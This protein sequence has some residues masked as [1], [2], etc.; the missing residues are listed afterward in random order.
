[1]AAVDPQPQ[2]I[3]WTIE[4]EIERASTLPS[5]VYCEPR[6]FALARARVFARGWQWAG[7]VDAARVPGQVQPFTL[8]E[9]LLDE[10]LLLARDGQDALRCLS[11]VCTHRGTVLCAGG[12]VESV[13]RCR[14]H[15]RR[16]ALDGRMLSMPE[17]EGVAGFP[18]S[19]DHLR[20]LPLGRWGKFLF[21]SLAG[22]GVAPLPPLHPLPPI[23]LIPPIV[24]FDDWI[25]PLV[26]RLRWLPLDAAVFDPA[27][28]RDYL[29]RAHWALYCDNYLE[30][31]HIPYVHAGLAGALDYGAYRTELYPWASLQ[32]GVASGGEDV[33]DLPPESPDHGQAIAAYYYWLFPNTMVNVYPWG[34]SVNVVR[35]LAVD[36]TKVSFL[37]YV[38]DASRL[39]SGA[40]AGLDR[41]ERED[42]AV[43]ESVQRGL[44][45]RIYRRGRYSPAREQG[46][47]HFHR[48]LT[49]CLAGEI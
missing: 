7:D 39:D 37:S 26:E 28:S 29:V 3:D 32:L 11:N 18:G 31:F 45:S 35:P 46:V 16:F 36:R 17:F 23:P 5:A 13:L 9:G 10:P 22:A 15:G 21:V 30:G 24:P 47:H 19:A 25:A 33:F 38:W 4:P 12:G 20:Q 49:R 41:V 43:V 6:L 48:L 42:E 40:G 14:Y 1:L 34:I 44:R 27:R 2:V 8:L